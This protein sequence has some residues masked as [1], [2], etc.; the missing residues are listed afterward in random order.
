MLILKALDWSYDSDLASPPARWD[1]T[2]LESGATAYLPG[3][4]IPK[5]PY[6]R[7][8]I[9]VTVDGATQRL[10]VG[11]VREWG[12]AETP[13]G[14]RTRAEGI[15]LK[16][17]L[18]DFKPTSPKVYKG[19]SIASDSTAAVG[20]INR[21][22]LGSNS[23][24]ADIVADFFH[25]FQSVV[26][27]V[28]KAAGGTPMFD[29]YDYYVA[30]EI[31]WET[32]QS[33]N[34]VLQQLL[35][36]FNATERFKIDVFFE[37]NNVVWFRERG[38]YTPESVEVDYKRLRQRDVRRS[39][40][41][42]FNDVQV[43]GTTYTHLEP[44]RPSGDTPI[45]GLAF[46]RP[47]TKEYTKI[48]REAIAGLTT[49]NLSGALYVVIAT[50]HGIQ[51]YDIAGRMFREVTSKV[52]SNY[53][54]RD[55]TTGEFKET[56][57]SYKRE[58]TDAQYEFKGPHDEETREVK[59]EH[60]RDT[61]DYYQW[62]DGVFSFVGFTNFDQVTYHSET[63]L[64]Y[65]ADG[66]VIRSHQKIHRAPQ[67]DPSTTIGPQS[68][69]LL[70]ERDV[71]QFWFWSGGQR[72]RTTTTRNYSRNSSALSVPT[73][74]SSHTEP[75]PGKGRPSVGTSTTTPDIRTSQRGGFRTVTAQVKAGPDNAQL[76]YSFPMLGRQEDCEYVRGKIITERQSTR[77]EATLSLYPNLGVIE[78]KDLTVAGAPA[79]W[80]TTSFYLVARTMRHDPDLMDMTVRGLAWL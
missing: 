24:G 72:L 39:D 77:Y 21:H 26:G 19:M 61:T 38:R 4:A 37:P 8:A 73:A 64:E 11:V 55:K 33:A 74:V 58:S 51:Y 41:P 46:I 14:L 17:V 75:S 53:V 9:D 71:E 45:P 65:D 54:L 32:E 22:V 48:E 52:Y 57:A 63:V 76:K 12:L 47:Y 15:D 2:F 49:A 7:A 36:P 59:I 31:N 16:A 18:L 68:A 42:S 23:E 35:S 27:D 62:D 10:V 20:S 1:C 66:E 6:E 43:L 50:T 28:V 13:E 3:E 29:G 70:V 5:S 69:A 34:D 56:R 80:E 44:D 30:Q 78:G 40:Y 67:P 79:R 60:V 25:T